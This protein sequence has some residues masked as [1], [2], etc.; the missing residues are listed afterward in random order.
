M[1]GPLIPYP[2]APLGK[3]LGYQQITTTLSAAVAVVFPTGT[4]YALI[5]AE[6]HNVRWT[7]DGS[8]PTATVGIPVNV[9]TVV[10]W[11]T[12]RIG[13]DWRCE[14]LVGEVVQ[15]RLSGRVF[16]PRRDVGVAAEEICRIVARL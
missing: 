3:P 4:T 9:A 7:D 2:G 15:H 10:G 8:T 12:N 5:Q 16:D 14:D 13:P 1:S 6:T 11:K